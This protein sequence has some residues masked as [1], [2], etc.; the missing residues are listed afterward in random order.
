MLGS[1]QIQDM[2]T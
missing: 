2:I 1:T